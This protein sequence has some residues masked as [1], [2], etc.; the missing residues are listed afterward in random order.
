M[1]IDKHKRNEILEQIAHIC[2]GLSVL[3]K[4]ID[5]F[6]HPG[7][8]LFAVLLVL[9]SVIVLAG[10]FLQK[11]IGLKH[12]YLK[13][14]VFAMES[15]AMALVGYAYMQDGTHLIHYFCFAVSVGFIITILLHIFVKFPK[16]RK[17]LVFESA[18]TDA[19]KGKTN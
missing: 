13:I 10:A 2:V 9:I 5:K 6:D 4:G 3:M 16:D 17:K 1:K 7:K 19:G 18:V 12:E 11:T 14:L 15:I 8:E